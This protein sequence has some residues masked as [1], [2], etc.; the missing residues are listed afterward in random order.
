[1]RKAAL[2]T[3][4]A[5]LAFAV[6]LPAAAQAYD[7]AWYKTD[8]WAGEWPNGFTL[9][10]D[11]TTK[12]RARPDKAAARIIDCAL[13]RGETYHQWN[14]DRV[15][16][17][18]LDFV[19]FVR[20][21][22]YVIK[23]PGKFDVQDEKTKAD[24]SLS[25]KAGE[26]WTYLTYYGEGYFRMEYKDRVYGA[27]Q[28]LFEHSKTKSGKRAEDEHAEDEWLNLLC[29]NKAKGWLL[30]T[31]IAEHPV[32]ERPDFPEYGKAVDKR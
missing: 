26:E 31:D 1:M 6:F 32:F 4:F 14:Q 19:T 21:V 28:S 2:T 11:V 5:G 15:L 12:L 25:L 18:R 9:K 8:F 17:S 13:K 23:T 30:Y 3:I 24:V 16:S 20:K 10:E 7:A 29:A 22:K 27:D